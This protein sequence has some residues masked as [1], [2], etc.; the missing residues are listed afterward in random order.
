MR[1]VIFVHLCQGVSCWEEFG[2]I[3]ADLYDD[4]LAARVY[5]FMCKCT[6]STEYFMLWSN[7]K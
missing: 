7:G 1:K 2:S 6:L 4:G 5:T 3:E